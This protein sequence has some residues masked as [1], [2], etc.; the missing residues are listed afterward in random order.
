MRLRQLHWEELG[1]PHESGDARP[2]VA[3]HATEIPALGGTFTATLRWQKIMLKTGQ[4]DKRCK[5]ENG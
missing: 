4:W 2:V 3:A 1:V 5:Q